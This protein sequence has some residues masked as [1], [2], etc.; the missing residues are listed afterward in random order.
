MKIH[1]LI[2]LAFLLGAC[3]SEVPDSSLGPYRLSDGRLVS[4]R[5]SLPGTLRLRVFDSGETRRYREA[6]G[7]W[8]PD[9]GLSPDS[10]ADSELMFSPQGF[11]LSYRDGREL[12]AERVDLDARTARIRAADITLHARLTLPSGNGPHPAV[13]LAHGSGDD[14]AT[15]TYATADFFPLF[16]VASLVYDKRGTGESGGEYNMDFDLLAND[17]VAVARWLKAQPGIDPS[18]IGVSGYSQGGWIGPLAVSKSSDLSFV[19]VNYGMIDSP[20]HEE[21]IETRELLARRGFE[22][23]ALAHVEALSD[24]AVDV[25]ASDFESGWERYEELSRQFADEPWMDALEDTTLESFEKWPHFAVRLI[26]PFLTPPGLDWDYD[27]LA[28]LDVLAERGVPQVWLIAEKDSSAPNEFTLAEL[29]RRVDRG[30]PITLRV[31][32]NTDHGFLMF[33]ERDA[34]RVY[35]NYHPDYFRTEVSWVLRL[36]GVKS[37]ASGE[38]SK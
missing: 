34:V 32:E 33:E 18:R 38:Q 27:S 11:S 20:R 4:I 9:P 14:A 30:E 31:F 10:L 13:I 15:R 36:A 3:T 23:E 21:R 1:A 16:G 22:G 35:G 2:G 26:G 8:R 25:M 6:D 37:A 29:R 17:V 19:V 5:A 24:A 28:A 7:V 12:R